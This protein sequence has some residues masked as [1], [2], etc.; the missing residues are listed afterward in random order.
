MHSSLIRRED[1]SIA[2]QLLQRLRYRQTI[3]AGKA[4]SIY[5]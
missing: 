2:G 4:V 3:N 5:Y 1:R